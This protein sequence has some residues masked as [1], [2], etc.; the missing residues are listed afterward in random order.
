MGEYPER[1]DPANW[2]INPRWGAEYV[3]P[4][5]HG[6]DTAADKLKFTA[7]ADGKIT[8]EQFIDS[9]SDDELIT[10]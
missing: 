8:I 2:P 6:I 1:I 3:I 7:V 4:N 10:L 5:E 9:L